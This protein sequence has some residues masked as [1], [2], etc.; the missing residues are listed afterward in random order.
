MIKL[1]N[2]L[3][4]ILIAVC[5]VTGT[6]SA[7]RP[8]H[9]ESVSVWE[10]AEQFRTAL[11]DVQKALL[12]CD[13]DTATTAMEQAR[14]LYRTNLQVRISATAHRQI[15]AALTAADTAIKAGDGLALAVQ[16]GFIW[17]SLLQAGKDGALNAL[18]SGDSIQASE[19]LKLREFRVSTKFTRPNADATL[20]IQS[21]VNGSMTPTD[22]ANSVRIDLLDTYQAKL[23]ESLADLSQAAGRKFAV[24]SAEEAG[25]A[26]GYFEILASSYAEQRDQTALEQVRGAFS[27]MTDAA[28]KSDSAAL[29]SA[30]ETIET[31]MQGF[32]A[33]PL[34]DKEAGR[35]ANQLLRFTQL[36]TVEY[37]RGVY[38][39]KVTNEIEI[40][41]ALTFREA[42]HA[43]FADVRPA[44]EKIDPGAAE[45]VDTL[46]GAILT[47]IN[48]VVDPAEVQNSVNQIA[49]IMDRIMPATWKQL[50]AGA[51][52]DV[53][54]GVLRQIEPALRIG[55]YSKAESL[56]IEAYAVLDS[57]IE[58]KLRGFAPDSAFLIENLF[59]QGTSEQP[60]LA[61]LINNK[62]PI[63]EIKKSLSVLIG[64]LKEAEIA[65]GGKSAPAAVATNAAVIVFREGLEAVLILA[66]LIASLRTAQTLKF[67][68]PILIGA[69]VSLIATAITWVVANAL[70]MSLIRYGEKLE[71]VVSLIAIGVL[72]LITNW[73]FHKVYWTG[74][75]ANFHQKKGKLIMGGMA[76]GQFMG[77]VIL[78][79]TS[80]YRE[81]FETV[82]FLQSLVLDAGLQVV[83]GGVA[84][85]LV[86]TAIV[87]VITFAFQV[88]LPYKKMLVVTGIM[89]GVV[90]LIMV[91]NTVHVLQ[92]VGWL[93]IT[94]I[95]GVF[96]PQWAGMWFGLYATWQGVFF[97][98]AAAAFVI[99]SYVL[100][101]RQTHNKSSSGTPKVAGSEKQV[102]VRR[103]VAAE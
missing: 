40:Q 21:V 53:V 29:M 73:F 17:A 58:Q 48:T 82:L 32:R 87:G 49:S 5:I 55:D 27:T 93:P 4:I 77:L 33:A 41:E 31:A 13:T 66:S 102:Q 34:S 12:T 103:S 52:F 36:V 25:L 37:P 80:I 98:F 101:E 51:D 61:T 100:A 79:F 83:L 90:L 14:A 26:Q 72:L 68:R 65:L 45:E 57:G 10:S 63:T 46:L 3:F 18:A 88:R 43:A 56:R 62:A 64:E 60:G 74:W 78:G 20:A 1:V 84:L 86:G 8:A 9:A 22:A 75:M 97:Q 59:W 94:P 19:W 44:L 2:R 39:G 23:N 71:A 54:R 30:F 6:F 96:L 15:Q 69:A 16:R 50:D 76:F 38:A 28:A 70:L 85:G 67:R 47:Q 89:I 11:F 7:A 99:G 95:Q 81:G 92:A 91:G 24:R 42:A 35:R